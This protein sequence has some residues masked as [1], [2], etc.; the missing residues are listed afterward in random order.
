MH[1][2]IVVRSFRADILEMILQPCWL[3]NEQEQVGKD[4][5]IMHFLCS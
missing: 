5:M 4:K 1:T 2:G 3:M